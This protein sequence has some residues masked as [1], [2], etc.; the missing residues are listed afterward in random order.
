MN[1]AMR[2]PA[3]AILAPTPAVARSSQAVEGAKARPSVAANSSQ[4]PEDDPV[5]SQDAQARELEA[6]T[7]PSA[8]RDR[9]EKDAIV[10]ES[11]NSSRI[12]GNMGPVETMPGRVYGDQDDA[13]HRDRE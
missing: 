3:T 1:P 5:A 2:A 10:W 13:G 7:H 9:C 8:G 11:P 6:P 4:S 12:N